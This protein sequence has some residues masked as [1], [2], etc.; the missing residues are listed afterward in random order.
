[1]DFIHTTSAIKCISLT[2]VLICQPPD[3][4]SL[5][6]LHLFPASH[7]I[8]TKKK[9]KKT[10]A[11]Q[12]IQVTLNTPQRKL[13][14]IQLITYKQEENFFL[15]SCTSWFP[16]QIQWLG[17]VLHTLQHLGGA[18]K[19]QIECEVQTAERPRS[20]STLFLVQKKK[21]KRKKS[22]K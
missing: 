8:S 7:V 6:S 12:R 18:L 10:N 20:P 5:I 9:I 14:T 17:T 2:M 13:T 22:C 1:M 21:T 15:S 16:F 11:A 4:P 3:T 19:S